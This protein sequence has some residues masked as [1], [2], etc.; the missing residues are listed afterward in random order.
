MF[1]A[2]DDLPRLPAARLDMLRKLSPPTAQAAVF[3]PE[4]RVGRARHNGR[5][6]IFF[7]NWND[8]PESFEAEVPAGVTVTDFWTGEAVAAQGGKVQLVDVVPHA[9]RI[10]VV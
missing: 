7:F 8:A 5:E 1:L 4:L 9:A 6:L 10:L 2:G 3:D